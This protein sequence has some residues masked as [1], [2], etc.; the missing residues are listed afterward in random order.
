MNQ[1]IHIVDLL[2][3]YLGDP[4]EVK[5]Y[6]G[7][8]HRTIEV[9]DTLAATLR[10]AGGAVATIT[11]TTTTAPGFPYRLEIYGTNGGIQVEGESIGRWQ[12]AD[13]GRATV[14]PPETG[15]AAE[16]G[17]GADPRGIAATGHIAI[18]RDFIEAIREDRSPKVDGAEGWR[19]LATVLA[20]YKSAGLIGD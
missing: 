15:Q 18:V 10:F 8:L 19:S 17:S 3:W 11:A 20:I 1:G 5:A 6:A 4:V 12:L 14:E 9:E 2:I 13:P 16:A 7:T